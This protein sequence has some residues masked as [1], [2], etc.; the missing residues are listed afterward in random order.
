MNDKRKI[1]ITI[2]KKGGYKFEAMEG[3]NGESCIEKTK[4]IEMVLGGTAVASGK[5]DDYYNGDS[6]ENVFVN[7]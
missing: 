1:R 4:N 7:L 5:K 2:D 6:P 3:F